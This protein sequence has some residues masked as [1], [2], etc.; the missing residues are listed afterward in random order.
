M[1]FLNISKVPF[2]FLLFIV[3]L[4]N[5]KTPEKWRWDN[6]KGINLLT[7]VRNQN[8]PRPCNSDWAFAA[9]SA[10]SDRI[11]II[12]KGKGVDVILSPQLLLS[13]NTENDGCNKGEAKFRLVWCGLK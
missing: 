8:L 6:Y 11:K 12:N 1:K 7:I 4:I 3:N 2:L 10:L 9:T 13:C 5:N